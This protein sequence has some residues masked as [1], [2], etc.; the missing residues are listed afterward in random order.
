[1]IVSELRL[2]REGLADTLERRTSIVVVASAP[3][4]RRAL[5]AVDEHAPDVLLLDVGLPESLALVRALAQAAPALKVVAFAVTETDSRLVD[6]I[7]AGVAGYI[8]RDGSLDDLMATVESIGRGEMLVSPRLAALVCRR[9]VALGRGRI[10][11]EQ[12]H[13]RSASTPDGVALTPR[14]GEILALINQGLANKE[15]ARQ[16]GIEVATVKNHVHHILEKLQVSRRGQAAARAS[17]MGSVPSVR[18]E[19][20]AMPHAIRMT[21]Q[22]SRR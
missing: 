4:A 20:S 9:L 21:G 2:L 7:E 1:V 16:L 14:E 3:D 15:I 11:A 12:R 13:D 22:Q 17:A 10:S 18:V 8:G 19:Y 5:T 6:C